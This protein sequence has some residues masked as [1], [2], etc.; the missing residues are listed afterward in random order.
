MTAALNRQADEATVLAPITATLR[1][2]FGTD[3]LPGLTPGLVVHDTA[4]WH[5]AGTLLDGSQLP[6]LMASAELRW[7]GAS[8]HAAVALAWKAYTYWLSLPAVLGWASARRVPLLTPSHVLV[9]FEDHR[10]LITFGLHPATQVAVLPSDPLVALDLPQVRVVADEA[11]MLGLLRDSL[12][13]AHLAPLS[14]RLRS[15]VRLGQRTLLG[16]L[17]SGIAHG[18]IRAA[19]AVPGPIAE[20]IDRLLKT[21]EVD[22]LVEV[23]AGATGELTVQR[24]TCCL[25]FTLPEPKVCAG[26][27]IR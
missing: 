5:P 7:R 18:L 8:P 15:E 11:T 9:H 16:S 23:V 6:N 20:T 21:L 1:A 22:D 2:M 4:G 10:P 27:C 3:R 17:A 26:C 14:D 19:D 13:D 24:K 25:A 12:L